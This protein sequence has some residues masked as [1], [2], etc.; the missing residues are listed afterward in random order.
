MLIS[1]GP[2]FF[3]GVRRQR[4][5]SLGTGDCGRISYL[6]AIEQNLACFISANEVAPALQVSHAAP[7]MSVQRNYVS[8]RN[9]SMKNPHFLVF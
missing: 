9:A 5:H 6:A 8:R 2:K 3:H 1:N 4:L 7:A